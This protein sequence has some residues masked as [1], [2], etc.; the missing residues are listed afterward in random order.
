MSI[1]RWFLSLLRKEVWWWT[2]ACEHWTSI[3]RLSR[4]FSWV[5]LAV[6][7]YCTRMS[8]VKAE[9]KS[10]E[11]GLRC[12][13]TDIYSTRMFSFSSTLDDTVP[14]ADIMR[15]MICFEGR[16]RT[17]WQWTSACYRG[18]W[19]RPLDTCQINPGRNTLADVLTIDSSAPETPSPTILHWVRR[20]I[21]WCPDVQ[22][23]SILGTQ[24]RAN[25]DAPLMRN[26]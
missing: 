12:N 3:M 8:G 10:G 22:R 6:E 24:D 15:W 11:S 17:P 23:I 16:L 14:S 20:R 26:L 13:K 7:R 4:D 18:C 2:M 21:G 5:H 1:R 19:F 25:A 9:G